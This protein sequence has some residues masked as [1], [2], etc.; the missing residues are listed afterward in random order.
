MPDV[1]QNVRKIYLKIYHLDLVKL[2]SAP[3]LAWQA[4]LKETEVKLELLTD[5]DM[6]LMVEKKIGGGI[7]HAIHQ[8]AKTNNKYMKDYDQNKESSYLKYWDIN[9]LYA[10]EMWQKLPL[11]KFEWI[12]DTSQFNEDFIKNYS[13]ESV[14]G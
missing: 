14:E 10:W 7:C 3:A 4:A 8:Y 9:N 1:F 2:L 6:L 5:I 12:E 11:N 13:E